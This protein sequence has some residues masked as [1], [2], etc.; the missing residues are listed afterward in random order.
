MMIE[1]TQNAVVTFADGLPGFE[2]CHQFV[3]VESE[4]FTPFRVVQGLGEGGPSFVGI[5]PRQ[6]ESAYDV[7]LDRGD[8]SRLEASPDDPLLWVAIVTARADRPATANLRAPI[9]INPRAMRGIQLL[10][11]ES[12]YSVDHPL[13]RE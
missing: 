7:R 10:P 9:V 4:T 5:D 11:T 13:S 2:S 8:L 12:A 3:L 6:V 1:T